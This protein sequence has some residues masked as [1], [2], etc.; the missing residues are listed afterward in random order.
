MTLF[1]EDRAVFMNTCLSWHYLTHLTTICDIRKDLSELFPV[2]A[3]LGSQL[4]SLTIHQFDFT[5][6]FSFHDL[7]SHC[8]CLQ[9]FKD[10]FLFSRTQF[11]G[12]QVDI[13]TLDW[14]FCLSR[15]EFSQ[16]SLFILEYSD[17][18]KPLPYRHAMIMCF[19]ECLNLHDTALRNTDEITL[20]QTK[21][22]MDVIDLILSSENKLS[23]LGLLKC[24]GIHSANCSTLLIKLIE[25]TFY[26]KDVIQPL[27]AQKVRY[28]CFQ[29]SQH[30][31]QAQTPVVTREPLKAAGCLAMKHAEGPSRPEP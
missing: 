1:L 22:S 5:N 17:I 18:E 26:E 9:E 2:A 27:S 28:E 13:E 6:E 12:L 19:G 30:F 16:L 25:R 11:H 29:K 14:D 23:Y 21:V 31:G 10:S 3:N 24:P 4:R 20:S 15:L 7:L 8:N